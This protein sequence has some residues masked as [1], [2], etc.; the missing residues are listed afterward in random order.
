MHM[1]QTPPTPLRKLP[2][3]KKCLLL[4]AALVL[5]I[6]VSAPAADT[7]FPLK[8]VRPGMRGIGKTVFN[9]NK[10]EEFNFEVLGVLQNIGPKQNAVLAR[11]YGGP[12]E[13]T[14]V[15]H[16]MSGSPVYIDGKLLGAVAF[17]LPFSKEPIAGITPIEEMISIFEEQPG[18]APGPKIQMGHLHWREFNGSGVAKPEP[19]T[20]TS[21]A[22][23]VAGRPERV[24]SMGHGL[25]PIATPITLAGFSTRAIEQFAPYFE[26]LGLRPVLGGGSAPDLEDDGVPLQPGSPLSVQL[27]RGDLNIN[28]SGTVTHVDGRRI[29]AFGHPFLS[30]GFTQLPFNKDRVLAILPS[31][32]ASS[33]ISVST[34]PLGVIQQDRA[35][36]ILGKLDAAAR[37]IPVHLKLHTSRNA[38]SSYDFEVVRDSFLSPLLLNFSVFSA[39]QSSER[40]AGKAT[41]RLKGKIAVKGHPEVA[42][43]DTFSGGSNP[44][45]MASLSVASPLHYL[46]SSGFETT[47]VERIDLAITSIEEE[48]T[49]L[50][51][52]VTYDKTKVRPGAEIMI[53]VNLK[54]ANQ[55]AITETYAVKI[56]DKLTPGPLSILI[57]DGDTLSQLDAREMP[58]QIVPENL[59]Q[60]IRAINN[61]KK[62]DRLYVRLFRRER[63]AIIKGE[64]FPSLPPSVLSIINAKKASGGV[65]PLSLT[66]LAEYELQPTDYV[67]SG[68]KQIEVEVISG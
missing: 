2:P 31:L 40:G 7:F 33:R 14:G 38:E 68:Q 3:R 17:A 26:S 23:P 44:A 37:M 18:M 62:N 34:K 59:N 46:L 5:L 43:E 48:R 55:E 36:G 30:A 15:Y 54:K 60:I 47:E 42:L 50:F 53:A 56:P 45:L 63:G 66:S 19:N 52:N 8:Q 32:F 28:A 12:L 11:L 24:G 4:T 65:Q 21:D 39:I 67:I 41:L 27:V 64:G 10:I 25:Q 13:R 20:L 35:T 16:G 29:Y 61:L 1:T 58:Q 6:G 49:V 9:G 22:A 57:C 51:N